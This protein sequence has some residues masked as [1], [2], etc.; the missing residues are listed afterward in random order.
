[1]G[2]KIRSYHGAIDRVVVRKKS[3]LESG[4][5]KKKEVRLTEVRYRFYLCKKTGKLFYRKFFVVDVRWYKR[6]FQVG[7]VNAINEAI[8]NKKLLAPFNVVLKTARQVGKTFCA[9]R[10]FAELVLY[11]ED[12]AYPIGTFF[13]PQKDQAKINAWEGVIEA[14]NCFPKA[15]ESRTDGVL[16]IP[17]PTLKNPNRVGQFFLQ[18]AVGG[19]QKKVGKTNLVTVFDEM[20]SFDLRFIEEA[21]YLTTAAT[22]GV[23]FFAG[24][25]EIDGEVSHRLGLKAS[26]I[27][28][29]KEAIAQGTWSGEIP[30]DIDYWYYS[31]ITA[32]VMAEHGVT[33]SKQKMDIMREFLSEEV[34]AKALDNVDLTLGR[35][36]YYQH[37]LNSISFESNCIIPNLHVD[38]RNLLFAYY[39]LGVGNKSDKMAIVLVQHNAENF[40]VL[41]ADDL[42][43]ASLM[44]IMD[45]G[46]SHAAKMTPSMGIFQHVLPHDGARKGNDLRTSEDIARDHLTSIGLK[47]QFHTVRCLPRPKNRK[48]TE[49]SV[50]KY[51]PRTTFHKVYAEPVINALFYHK[52]QEVPPKSGNF[53]DMP[54]KTKYRDLE[55]AFRYACFDRDIKGHISDASRMYVVAQNPNLVDPLKLEQDRATT[56][57]MAHPTQGSIILKD[58]NAGNQDPDCFNVMF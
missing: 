26:R 4:A 15:R 48:L 24:T 2:D 53:A 21:G 7:V 23:N 36:Y 44:D 9:T 49:D 29:I 32:S 25:I 34:A 35:R 13:N 37:I 3:E 11:R 50:R 22:E 31:S 12:L 40:R 41:F 18:G 6:P 57:G 10:S 38:P 46:I 39:D 43:N 19:H 5:G 27:T 16:T 51:L 30:V 47:P 58:Y 52:R 56:M 20:D 28:R 42:S 55:S 14:L 17:L 45:L 8:R 33:Y 1:M 54:A